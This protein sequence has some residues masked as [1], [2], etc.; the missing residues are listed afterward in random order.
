MNEVLW[1]FKQWFFVSVVM[2][3]VF[4]NA[5]KKLKIVSV[6]CAAA[7]LRGWSLVVPRSE[8]R[9]RGARTFQRGRHGRESYC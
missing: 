6:D 9:L 7:I 5:L 4:C 1:L 8:V 2:C 3:D